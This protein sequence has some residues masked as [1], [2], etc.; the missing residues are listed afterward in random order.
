MKTTTVTVEEMEQRIVRFDKLES[1]QTQQ[2]RATGVPVAVLEK[3]AARRV[4]PMMVPDN[5]AGRSS[6]APFRGAPG[7]ALTIAECPP[8][9]GPGLHVHERTVENFFCL[10]GRFRISWGDKGERSIVLDK[11][12][13]VS[14]PPG[15]SRRFE[16]ISDEL[17]RL[18]VMIQIPA[19]DRTDNVSYAPSVG[20]EVEKEFGKKAVDQ[21]NSIG[22]KFDAEAAT[23]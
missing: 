8:G 22:F 19:G 2:N 10:Q 11:M 21:L 12:D 18:L 6:L 15:I 14:V 17:G 16:N 1:Y 20:E 4:Y 5:Y 3:L 13:M 23:P 7:L 9:D